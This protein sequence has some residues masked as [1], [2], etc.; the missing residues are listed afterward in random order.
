MLDQMTDDRV[1]EIAH[2]LREP[3]TVASLSAK[4]ML[5]RGVYDEEALRCIVGATDRLKHLIGDLADASLVQAGAL[6]L[7]STETDLV[8]LAAASVEQARILTT[9]HRLRLE[10]PA[11]PVV[12]RW[13]PGRIEQVLANLV[14]NAIKYSPGGEI[15]VRIERREAAARITVRDEGPG[16]PPEV[17]PYVFERFYRAVETAE[18]V[19]GLGLGLHVSKSLVEAHGGRLWAESAPGRGSAFIF[20]L[21]RAAPAWE[22]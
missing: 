6:V 16:I 5:R 20:E 15:V 8:T 4:W 22:R 11:E 3:L 19:P 12:G 10:A 7:R 17:L 2:E 14:G 1:L 18:A 9:V 13:D 21:P